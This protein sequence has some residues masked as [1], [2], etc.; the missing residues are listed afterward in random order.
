LRIAHTRL[1]HRHLLDNKELSKGGSMQKA[2]TACIALK[3][4]R[5]TSSNETVAFIGFHFGGGWL[6][7]WFLGGKEGGSTLLRKKLL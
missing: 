7:I 1:I 2:S 6:C 4:K 3:K 5:C